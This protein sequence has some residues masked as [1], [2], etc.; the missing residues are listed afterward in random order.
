MKETPK[1]FQPRVRWTVGSFCELFFL[2]LELIK[3]AR[4]YCPP[5]GGGFYIF[6]AIYIQG[7]H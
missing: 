1:R 6:G 5:L 4:P 3:T 2:P 7:N